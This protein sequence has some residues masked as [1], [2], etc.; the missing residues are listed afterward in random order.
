MSSKNS[1]KNHRPEI[2]PYFYKA[3]IDYLGEFLRKAAGL[4]IRIRLKILEK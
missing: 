4:T 3:N 1:S 2:H